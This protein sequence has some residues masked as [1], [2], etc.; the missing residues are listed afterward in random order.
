MGRWTHDADDR[1]SYL[2]AIVRRIGRRRATRRA[3]FMIALALSVPACGD[4]KAAEGDAPSTPTSTA[5]T[6]NSTTAPG[7]TQAS[8]TTQA[9]LGSTATEC[10]AALDQID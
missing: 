1:C 8:I 3:L 10:R 9:A 5:A 4:S 6:S 7:N 2:R